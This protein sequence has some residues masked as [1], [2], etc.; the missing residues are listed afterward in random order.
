MRIKKK[1]NTSKFEI[2]RDEERR[3]NKK[4][5]IKRKSAFEQSFNFI[6]LKIKINDL[7]SNTIR[8]SCLK[9]NVA[10]TRDNIVY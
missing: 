7:I 8:L 9:D 3:M 2:K 10:S 6:I 1:E 5:K 4:I